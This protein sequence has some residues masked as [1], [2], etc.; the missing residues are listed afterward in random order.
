MRERSFA[1]ILGALI[2]YGADVALAWQAT[3]RLTLVRQRPTP[4]D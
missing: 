3:E 1:L 2:R 4:A